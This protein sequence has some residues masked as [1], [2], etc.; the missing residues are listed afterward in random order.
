MTLISKEDNYCNFLFASF[1]DKP[2]KK[3]STLKGKSL[4]LL[5]STLK[6]ENLLPEEQILSSQS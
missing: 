5:G 3:L 1:E 4:L 2:F 6:G